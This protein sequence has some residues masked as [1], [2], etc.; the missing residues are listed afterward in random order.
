MFY[1]HRGRGISIYDSMGRD[2]ETK[3][4]FRSSNQRE[5]PS[6]LGLK[7]APHT[8]PEHPD[9]YCQPLPSHLLLVFS[10]GQTHPE[11]RGQG[12]PLMQSLE[13][14]LSGHRGDGHR[15]AE[16]DPG[17][18]METMPSQGVKT[19]FQS[20]LYRKQ[21]HTVYLGRYWVYICGIT[22]SWEGAIK[23]KMSKVVSQGEELMV[24][25]RWRNSD[26]AQQLWESAQ[27]TKPFLWLIP[28]CKR[29]SHSVCL[30]DERGQQECGARQRER[31]H[32][33]AFPR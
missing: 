11:A 13:V 22:I 28:N 14:F 7:E 4:K 29:S 26:L 15:R 25:T 1:F 10:I 32:H 6:R 2:K 20:V 23:K 21:K 33:L 8:R 12:G 30:K 27:V 16:R 3:W 5:S 17:G 18:Q 31:I 9:Q 19:G 24:K